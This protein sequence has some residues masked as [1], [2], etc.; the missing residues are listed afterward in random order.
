MSE[1]ALL[2]FCAVAAVLTITPG[3]DTLLVLRNAI[4]GG[5]TDGVATMFGISS[6]LL[7][8]ASLSAL[9]LSVLLQRSAEAYQVVQWIGAAYL[10]WLG[11]DSWRRSR[12]VP[13]EESA[14]AMAD[15]SPLPVA[16]RRSFGEGFLTNLLNPKV[17][18]FYLALL[19][20][21]VGSGTGALPRS[22]FLASI[23]IGMGVLWLGVLSLTVN[24]S[25]RWVRRGGVRRW[26]ER[27]S[28]SLLLALGVRLALDRRP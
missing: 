22:L 16:P 6:G 4:R 24:A 26:M 25:R 23:H 9:G 1:T 5:W 7:V 19:P 27:V 2:T 3:A 15:S 18:L 8:H 13:D 10:I 21:F 17:A 20:Q 14:T 11:I 12:H 28:G